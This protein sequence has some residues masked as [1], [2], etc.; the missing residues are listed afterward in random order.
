MLLGDQ[1]RTAEEVSVLE[2]DRGFQSDLHT[3]K[4]YYLGLLHL[5]NLSLCHECRVNHIR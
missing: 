2:N 5:P 1:P 3:T 4:F